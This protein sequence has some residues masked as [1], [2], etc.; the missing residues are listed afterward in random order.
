MR[1]RLALALQLSLLLLPQ[2]LVELSALARLVAVQLRR[3]RGVD[4]ARAVLLAQLVVVLLL[5][6]RFTLELVG[7]GTLILCVLLVHVATEVE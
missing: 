5:A 1:L 6:L 7:D 3:Q 2:L 4:L